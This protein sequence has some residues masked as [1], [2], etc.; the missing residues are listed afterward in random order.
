MIRVKKPYETL[1]RIYILFCHVIDCTEMIDVSAA[2]SLD[3]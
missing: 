2:W 1:E 3:S